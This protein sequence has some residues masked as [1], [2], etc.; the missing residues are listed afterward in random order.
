M[1]VSYANVVVINKCFEWLIVRQETIQVVLGAGRKLN[2]Y[3]TG[4]ESQ[5]CD[6]PIENQKLIFTNRF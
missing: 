1:C 4:F 5:I 2:V 3:K 6:Q